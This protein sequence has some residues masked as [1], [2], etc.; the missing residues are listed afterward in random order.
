[1]A[2]SDV[3]GC[4]DAGSNPSIGQGRRD[5]ALPDA[6]SE[7]TVPFFESRWLYASPVNATERHLGRTLRA[8]Y[9]ALPTPPPSEQLCTLLRKL[10]DAVAAADPTP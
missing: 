7:T 2:K 6:E 3:G 8:M 1:M 9:E 5:A 10:D 4:R